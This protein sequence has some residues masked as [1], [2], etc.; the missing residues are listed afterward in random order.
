MR[1]V[2]VGW[3]ARAA[4]EVQQCGLSFSAFVEQS[5][6]RIL[7]GY[8]RAWLRDAFAAF[9]ASAVRQLVEETR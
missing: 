3:L 8:V 6:S 1:H 9:N 2:K 7:A 5:Q 4:T